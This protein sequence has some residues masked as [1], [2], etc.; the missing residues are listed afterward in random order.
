MMETWVDD[1]RQADGQGGWRACVTFLAQ[2]ETKGPTSPGLVLS[3]VHWPGLGRGQEPAGPGPSPP[4]FASPAASPLPCLWDA[5][6]FAGP[7][8]QVV[9]PSQQRTPAL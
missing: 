5:Q 1:R 2:A 9:T 6:Q 4:S 3:C 7:R 8:P